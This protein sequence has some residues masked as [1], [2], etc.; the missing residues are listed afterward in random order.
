M[1]SF[2]G[3]RR[4]GQGGG[5]AFAPHPTH[6]RKI[7]NVKKLHGKYKMNKNNINISQQFIQLEQVTTL[8]TGIGAVGDLFRN[9]QWTCSLARSSGCS[10]CRGGHLACRGRTDV[11][12][13]SLIL[14]RCS[15]C[16]LCW[17]T[18]PL[19]I[20]LQAHFTRQI[21]FFFC[22]RPWLH[23][24]TLYPCVGYS[25]PGRVWSSSTLVHEYSS[26]R[27][28]LVHEYSRSRC[29]LVHEYS[30]SRVL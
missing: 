28:T 8:G 3:V 26:S 20:M 22:G 5:G 4:Q 17:R 7:K 19:Y 13:S 30:S 21:A 16:A 27:C 18:F 23:Y 2:M 14:T 24:I 6:P 12:H 25:G 15:P 29:T 9:C 11:Y 10:L 1:A